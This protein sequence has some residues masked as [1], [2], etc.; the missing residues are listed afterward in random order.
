[1]QTHPN[2]DTQNKTSLAKTSLVAHLAQVPDPRV[3]RTKDH[4]LVDVLVIAV[5][6]LLC[7]GSEGAGHTFSEKFQTVL[8]GACRVQHGGDWQKA[9]AV[10]VRLAAALR[11]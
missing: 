5:C 10:A 4:E 8:L 6:T 2:D 7:A 1:M 11:R 3:N 9:V